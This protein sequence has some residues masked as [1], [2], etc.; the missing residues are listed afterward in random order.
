[1]LPDLQSVFSKYVGNEMDPSQSLDPPDQPSSLLWASLFGISCQKKSKCGY[2]IEYQ[3]MEGTQI[4]CKVGLT[5][6][7]EGRGCW[8]LD[9][10]VV[11][12]PLEERTMQ[13]SVPIREYSLCQKQKWQG[14]CFSY[15]KLYQFLNLQ[16]ECLQFQCGGIRFHPLYIIWKAGSIM[17]KSCVYIGFY[18]PP[19]ERSTYQFGDEG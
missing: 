9:F 5:W 14:C 8:C 15:S 6:N 18:L 12:M 11:K 19:K 3:Y 4:G 7:Q 16:I 10:S 2:L 17:S 1:M 13:G